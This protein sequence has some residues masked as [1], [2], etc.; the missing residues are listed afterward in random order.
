[1][2]G[3]G[4]NSDLLRKWWKFFMPIF[5]ARHTK[6]SYPTNFFNKLVS[7]VSC[8]KHH[9]FVYKWDQQFCAVRATS[10]PICCSLQANYGK[11]PLFPCPFRFGFYSPGPNMTAFLAH[12]WINKT[13][14]GTEKKSFSRPPFELRAS[15]DGMTSWMCSLAFKVLFKMA[16]P[17]VKRFT[18]FSL[19][20]QPLQKLRQR[21]VTKLNVNFLLLIEKNTWFLEWPTPLTL[22]GGC[23][24]GQRN[25]RSLVGY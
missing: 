23:V 17:N 9:S 2:T 15:S 25:S 6:C 18:S 11:S 19:G 10:L 22:K 12:N 7:S 14:F 24:T 5:I 3:F 8:H 20:S 1:M 13:E 4:F 16:A 21:W